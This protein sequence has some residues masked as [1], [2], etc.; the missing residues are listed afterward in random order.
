MKSSYFLKPFFKN[1]FSNMNKRSYRGTKYSRIFRDKPTASNYEEKTDI[2]HKDKELEKL[3]ENKFKNF[4]QTHPN[5][6]L[7][8]WLEFPSDT[9][10]FRDQLKERERLNKLR[11]Q[12]TKAFR[13]KVSNLSR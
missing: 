5:S 3:L 10:V 6:D 8:H 11:D 1:M 9:L 13:P 12:T 4:K 2:Y 7:D